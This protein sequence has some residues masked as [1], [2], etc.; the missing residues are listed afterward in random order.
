MVPF[1]RNW[2]IPQAVQIACVLEATAP[3]LGNV[4]PG[5][6]FHDMRFEHFVASASAIACVYHAHDTKPVGQL[7]L[8]SVQQ[9]RDACGTNTHLGTTLLLAPLAHAVAR[10][11]AD[12]KHMTTQD[13]KLAVS[14]VL[15]ELT[16]QDTADVYAAI[17]LTQPGGLGN[18][19]QSDVSGTPPENLVDAMRLAPPHDSVAQQYVLGFAD[20]LERIVP[21]LNEYLT[22]GC[23]PLTAITHTQLSWLSSEL[24]GLIV[25][26]VGE[27]T[28]TGVQH[29]A[30]KILAAVQSEGLQK[31]ESLDLA[32]RLDWRQLDTYMR[33]TSNK[34]NPGTTADLI[35]AALFVLLCGL[36]IT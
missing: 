14:G 19:K 27:A 1:N 2:S 13:L 3:K 36:R 34:M 9:M 4:H 28:A 7:V 35:A 22:A 32:S 10:C 15:D 5:A 20:V 23:D 8:E 30:S 11:Q 25:R 31:M 17:R 16:E 18:A 21:A 6:S 24:D 29:A 26:K 33:S 12:S